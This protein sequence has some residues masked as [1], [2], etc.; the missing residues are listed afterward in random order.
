[1]KTILILLITALIAVPSV[2]FAGKP[3][4]NPGKGHTPV[5]ICHHAGPTKTITITVDDDAVPAHLAHGD[6]IGAC[7]VTPP[8]DNGGGTG[9]T[10]T[11]TVTEPTPT[12]TTPTP[13]VTEPTPTTPTTVTPPAKKPP[14][15]KG[16]VAPPKVVRVHKQP[17]AA[18]PVA[19]THQQLAK[20]AG[21]E[22]LP[23]TGLP[24]GVVLVAGVALLG[25]G[26]AARRYLAAE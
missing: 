26:V 22:S 5:T 13:T 21:G 1:M 23:Y 15:P 9:T 4:S 16:Q 17:A 8:D 11:P 10:P 19:Q 24:V 3:T 7:P 18:P 25:A 20:Q 2:A 14:K 12:D 6:T